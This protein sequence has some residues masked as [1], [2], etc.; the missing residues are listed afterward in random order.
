MS[1]YSKRAIFDFFCETKKMFF[2]FL[3]HRSKWLHEMFR[4]LKTSVNA[5]V[6]NKSLQW[7]TYRVFQTFHGK[8]REF[9]GIVG[10]VLHDGPQGAF[11][12][13]VCPCVYVRG[14][15]CDDR[16]QRSSPKQLW[17]FVHSAR[18]RNERA[19]SNFMRLFDCFSADAH[20]FL[21]N[22]LKKNMMMRMPSAAV[23]FLTGG[24]RP[25]ATRYACPSPR[26]GMWRRNPKFLRLRGWWVSEQRKNLI[27]FWTFLLGVFGLPFL[28]QNRVLRRGGRNFSALGQ[29]V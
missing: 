3:A 16:M 12:G 13:N 9:H 1:F 6:V 8:G 14:N 24:H 17:A 2:T 15:G 18:T 20:F 4:S 22:T 21:S 26:H 27:W 5:A 23:G 19:R 28:W 11:L 25:N 10:V 7:H 29:L